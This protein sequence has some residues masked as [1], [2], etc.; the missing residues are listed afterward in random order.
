M[1]GQRTW[2]RGGEM[3]TA[4]FL[5]G[6]L[7]FW[8]ASSFGQ[9]NSPSPGGDLLSTVTPQPRS[10]SAELTD[11]RLASTMNSPESPPLQSPASESEN[12]VP[13]LPAVP[14]SIALRAEFTLDDDER[15][16]DAIYHQLEEGGYLAR[17]DAE[18]KSALERGIEAV[19]L[20]E[21][22]RIGRVSVYC[23]LITAIKRKNPLCLLNPIVLGASW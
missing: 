9:T 17:H 18:S 20:P 4:L 5:A 6:L 12:S 7:A 14:S 13:V 3:S 22:V 8:C 15:K 1:K 16:I 19:F 23:S 10:W 2:I 11:F 21:I